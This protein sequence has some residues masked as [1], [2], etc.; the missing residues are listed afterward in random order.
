MYVP[1]VTSSERSVPRLARKFPVFA[2][3][4]LANMDVINLMES[5]K[6]PAKLYRYLLTLYF[7]EIVLEAFQQEIAQNPVR[8]SFLNL[9]K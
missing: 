8:K 7:L 2:A 4:L 6:H 9:W 1:T 5:Y 3:S